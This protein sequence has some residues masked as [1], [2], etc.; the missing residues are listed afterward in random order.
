MNALLWLLALLAVGGVAAYRQ[1]GRL[2]ATSAL[3]GTLL[4]ASI[5]G[6]FPVLLALVLWLLWGAFALLLHADDWRREYVTGRV[7]T[8]YRRQLPPLSDTEREAMAAGTV[9]WDRELFSGQPDWDL[10]AGF[11]DAP[12]TPAEQAFLGGPVPQ[13]CALLDDWRITHQD[14]DLPA[15]VWKFMREQGFFGLIIPTEYGG[16][17]FS[18][19]THSAV[20]M[21]L[22]SRSVTAAITVMVPNSLGPAEL[23]RHYG[24]PEQKDHYLPR[25]AR[26]QDIPCFALTGPQAG[27]DASA[28]PDIGVVCR[29]SHDGQDVLGVRL[30]F[31]KRYITLA[32]VATVIG[33][34]FSLR[35]P[36]GL[37]AG[38][39][40]RGITVLLLPADA[41]GVRSGER[42]LP[43]D[44]PFQNGPLH[45]ENVFA[46]LSWIIGGEAGIGRGWEMLVSCLSEGRGISLPALSTG[47][48]KVAARYTGAY[49]RL[50]EQF[51]VPV[52]RFEGVQEALARIAGNCYQ[53]DAARSLT[54]YGLDHGEKPAVLTAILKYH[55]TER[56]RRVVNDAMDVQA[57]SGVMMGPRN[58]LARYYQ[59]MP[60]AITVEGANILTRSLI[61]FGQG[62]VRAHPYVLDEMLAVQEQDADL[63]VE[64]FDQLLLGHAGFLLGNAARSFFLGLT[65]GRLAQVPGDGVSGRYQ[66]RLSWMSA[67]FAFSADV[68]MLLVGGELKRR[69]RLS[70]RLG[71]VLSELY[72][73]SAVLR[74]F[75]QQDQPPED[76]PLARWALDDCLARIGTA[77]DG[78]FAN[79]PNR[80]LGWLLRWLVFPTGQPH[81]GPDDALGQQVAELLLAPGDSRDRLTDGIYLSEDPAEATGRLE[82]ALAQA[83]AAGQVQRKLRGA[84]KSGELA[85]GADEDLLAQAQ[86]AGVLDAGEVALLGGY[87]ELLREIIAVD[88]FPAGSFRRVS[89]TA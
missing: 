69:E 42:H 2:A 10:L 81:H 60:V 73:A 28:L 39:V 75:Q 3:G 65:R 4:L 74:H 50:R 11:V 45:G 51:G 1:L 8:F 83:D 62:A 76:L 72:L 64:R 57:G 16:Q 89:T 55:L 40:E 21:Q 84:L 58:F 13:L 26:G 79:Y 52:G 27:S 41:P 20:V 14:A 31:E 48:A 85:V 34:A 36:D 82:L 15:P 71:D 32:P 37:L 70:A 35:D 19:R 63:A 7:L 22:A 30:N 43:L 33:L 66:Q 46:P 80:A 12:F 59:V 24:T 77:F 9:W 38:P 68:T 18:H 87:Q 88:A 5:S 54:L 67:A 17:G 53:M 61:I 86:A 49:A 6:G 78:L 23:L 56:G 44:V 47:V 25:L 29:G